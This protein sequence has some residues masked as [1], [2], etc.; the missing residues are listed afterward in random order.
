MLVSN[1]HNCRYLSGFRG[2]TGWLLISQGEAVIAVDFRYV[3]QARRECSEFALVRVRGDLG[4]W[5]PGQTAKMGIKQLAVESQ[6]IS[7]EAYRKLIDR[8]EHD[9]AL[10]QVV[11]SSDIVES[12]RQIKD[13]EELGAVTQASLLADEAFKHIRAYVR[14]G[15]TERHL[16][17]QLEKYLRE[18]GSETIPF[19][20]IVASGPNTALPHASP[21]DRI[22]GISEP[23]MLDYGSRVSGYSSDITRTICIGTPDEMF[24]K[25][26]T[27]VLGAQTTAV[28]TI[29]AGMTGE[30]A[31][32]LART[33]IVGAGFGDSFG[34]GLGH[35]LGLEV[36][37]LPRL[38]ARST[39][40]LATGMTFTVEPGVYL[41]G[42]GGVRIEDTVVIET[43]G[44]RPLTRAEKSLAS[45]NVAG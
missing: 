21:S 25:V 13:T 26:Y 9:R 20:I 2:S 23:V 30:Q 43:R 15:M 24:R 29:H 44:L 4:D 10:L 27:A 36:H 35:G 1:I 33:V 45:A 31:D 8:I 38:G 32:Q 16:A 18:N 6:S 28:A 12:L 3:E 39:D 37:E 5:L 11:P 42:W 19:D 14:A 7:L 41:P 40:V 34:H 17:W 22:I